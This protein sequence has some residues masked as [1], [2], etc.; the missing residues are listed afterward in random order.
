MAGHFACAFQRQLAAWENSAGTGCLG[1]HVCRVWVWDEDG[2]PI[3]NIQLYTTWGVLMGATDIDGRA[4]IP[5]WAD[6]YNLKCV[7]SHGST[8]DAA[9]LMTT[10]RPECWGHYSFEVGFLYKTDASNPGEFDLD[11][12]CT[13]NE[14]APAPQDNDVPYTKSLAYSGVD[15]TDYWSDQSY[16][17]NWQNPPS[18]FGQTF[19][20]TGDRVVAARVQG[21]IG[22]LGLLDWKLRIVTFPALQPVGPDTSVP[23]RWPF[24]WEAFW[25]VNDCPVVPGQKYM[26]QVWRD[27]GGMNI[28]HVTDDV[29][30]DGQY[31]EGTT[32]FPQFDL[33]GHIC[34]M[35]YL[36][37]SVLYVD[38]SVSPG[39]NGRSWANAYNDLQD[40]LAAAQPGVEIRVAQGVYSPGGPLLT[41]RQASNPNPPDGAGVSN[42]DADLSWT[43]GTYATSHD[44]YFG[45]TSPGIFQGNQIATTFDPGTMAMGTKY[46]WRIDEVGSS[47]TTTGAIWSFTT[48]SPPPPPPLAN[49]NELA[50]PV[51]IDRTA[52]FQLKNGVVIKGG[53]A[54]FGELDPNARDIEAYETVLSGDIG[55][56]GNNLDNSLHVVTGSGTDETAI[57]DGFTITAGNANRANPYNRGGGMYNDESS[58]TIANCI[59][60]GNT[61]HLFGGAV[62]NRY[63]NPM[64]LSCKFVQNS[65]N[66]DGGAMHN[67]E[68]SPIIINSIFTSNSTR[69]W[70][71]AIRN[72]ASSGSISNCLF[73]A[74]TCINN[75][76]AISNW[77]STPNII[78]CTF[79]RNSSADGAAIWSNEFSNLTIE[80]SIIWSN[81]GPEISG[82]ETDVSYSD[83]EGGWPGEGNIDADPYFVEA[84][85]WE[86]NG[87]PDDTTDDLWVDGD[88][89]LLPGSPCINAG[90]PDYIAEPNEI[91]LDGKPRVIA[92]RIDM[93]AY[94]FNHVPIADA[95]PDR[96]VE[97]QGHWGA[98]VTLDASGSSDADSTSGTIDDINDFNWY[99]LDP[100]DPNADVFLGNGRI[101]DCNLSIGDHI[102]LLEVIDKAGA[103]DTKEVTIIVQ[104]TTPPDINCPPDVI[105]ECP[106]DT[107]LSATGKATATDSC[108]TVTITHSDQW[109]PSCGNAGT[110]AR[111]WTATDESG[112]SSSC[113]QIITV[114]DMTPPAITCPPNVT[115]QCPA[116]TS[117]EANGS[118]SAVDTCSSVAITHSD[119]WQPAC[120]NTGILT[121]T[122]TATD[123]CGNS[124]S[125]LQ[126]LT[127]V[128]T[129]PPQFQFSVAPTMLWPPD[130]KMVLITPSW[131]VSDEC[132]ATPDVSLV[133]IIANEGD[134]TIG[135]G[136]TSNDI[137]IGDD[138]SIYLRSERSG[139]SNDRVYTIT[140][141]AVDDCGNTTVRS[142]TVSIPHDFKV[143]ARIADRWLWAG[144]GR[145]PEDLNGDGFVNLK[146]IAIFA[147]NWIQ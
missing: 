144:A 82:N 21:T 58:P 68:S 101:V 61:A 8:S 36:R 41:N 6:D 141:Q 110:L 17:G 81:E 136:H 134:N 2:K 78:N 133:S 77:S 37:P 147:N 118:S 138:G 60:V 100:C 127:V 47:G 113:V 132:D 85:Y 98:A 97:A 49:S 75:G 30:P 124:S 126:T 104:D 95:G 64:I 143:L 112:N 43:P 29:Y 80:N 146:D 87:T 23:V 24:G 20:A 139:I 11:L 108:G 12:N 14:R 99:Q 122:W 38:A 117:V 45:T 67:Y 19:I 54:G 66:G 79:T 65:T 9:L 57:L 33:N 129:M 107:T 102:I 16:W 3:P 130:H 125:C 5:I 71:G 142:A 137:Q 48:L 56:G 51:A 94:E 74:N 131:T 53:Y 93:G 128:D 135:D 76:G 32:P 31:Y 119:L 86:T 111:T 90:D 18:Y 84:G 62:G 10:H 83:I 120:G 63:S 7:D 13:W 89:H 115:L 105:L 27:G 50:A 121:R 69:S 15:C 35:N 140:Y 22:G 46:Y 123:D 73:V 72:V 40:A 103:S 70:G 34:C 91:D 109:Q 96:T 92:G 59:F 1:G 25:G 28:Y 26:L 44:V 39:G 55:I 114:V 116:D 52:T 106:A 145:I 42:L 4:E 88:C